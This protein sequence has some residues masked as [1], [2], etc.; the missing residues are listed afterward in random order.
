MGQTLWI[1]LF[2]LSLF[3][4]AAFRAGYDVIRLV[5]RIISHKLLGCIFEDVL[6]VLLW[7]IVI[8]QCFFLKRGCGVR[9][10]CYVVMLA[11]ALIYDAGIGRPVMRLLSQGIYRIKKRLKKQWKLRKMKVKEPMKAH[12]EG[13][14]DERKTEKKRA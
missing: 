4:G 10:Y 5:R 1:E 9:A 2:W 7:G 6:Y 3:L 14:K 11:G 12:E 13:I 8:F